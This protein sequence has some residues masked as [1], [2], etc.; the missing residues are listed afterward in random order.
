MPVIVQVIFALREIDR[1]A[2]MT[3]P[4][5]GGIA[6][7]TATIAALDDVL[8]QAGRLL[9]AVQATGGVSAGI[10]QKVQAVGGILLG[11]GA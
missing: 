11:K 1:L 7:N 8:A 4:A 2:K 9:G 10:H 3:L 5:A 6:D